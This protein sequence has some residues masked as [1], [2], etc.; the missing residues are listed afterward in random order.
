MSGKEG[1]ERIAKRI[2]G[3]GLC[4]RREAERWIAAGRVAV[5][6]KII[7]SPALDV[8]PE[9]EIFV[10]GEPIAGP[11][12]VRLWRY[13]KPAGLLA[14]HRDPQGRPTLFEHMPPGMPR[15]IS[16]GRLD[17]NSEGLILLCTS[18]ELARHLELPATGLVRRYRVR[19][20]GHVTEQALAALAQGAEVEGV[21]YGPINAA[22]ERRQGSNV[23]L[24]MSLTEGKNREVRR[25]CEH[26]GLKV[27]RLIRVSYGPFQLGDLPKGAAE[28]VP[29]RVLREQLGPEAARLVPVRKHGHADHRRDA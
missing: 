12:R 1:R 6:G 24:A 8:G 15:V 16:V 5:D 11:A 17:L 27:N 9:S 23:W 21:R 7:A 10:D 28:E 25:I 18:G 22:L 13:H 29:T 20:H 2:A 4:S 26:L 14:T 3:A 19:A